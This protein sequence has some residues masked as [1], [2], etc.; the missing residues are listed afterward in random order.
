MMIKTAC[1]FWRY[2]CQSLLN[3]STASSVSGSV[4][5]SINTE[6]VTV[7]SCAPASK[8][9]AASTGVY[10]Y[11]WQGVSGNPADPSVYH[12][13]L[14]KTG[15]FFFLSRIDDEG[16]VEPIQFASRELL[17]CSTSLVLQEVSSRSTQ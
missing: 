11:D 17:S 1:Y 4:T 10:F 5:I 9:F 8:A 16:G 15:S 12:F 6:G 2:R 13:G 3:F 7:K 14:W